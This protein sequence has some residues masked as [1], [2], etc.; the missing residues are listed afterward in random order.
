MKI[1]YLFRH[2]FGG[3]RPGDLIAHFVSYDALDGAFSIDRL[4][5]HS[6]NEVYMQ[7]KY[8]LAGSFPDVHADVISIRFQLPVDRV[9][10]SFEKS[11]SAAFFFYRKLEIVIHMPFSDDEGMSLAHGAPI[12]YRKSI[13]ILIKDVLVGDRTKWTGT[14]FFKFPVVYHCPQL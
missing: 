4:S 6:R 2:Y 5:L 14:Q 3:Q 9:L 1:L 12:P 11:C 7:M 10:H 13:R 8:F